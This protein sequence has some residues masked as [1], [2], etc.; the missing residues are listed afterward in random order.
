MYAASGTPLTLVKCDFAVVADAMLKVFGSHPVHL[1]SVDAS[2]MPNPYGPAAGEPI[3]G[4]YI[5]T[6]ATGKYGN[7]VAALTARQAANSSTHLDQS[8]MSQP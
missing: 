7:D 4:R 3:P 2:E 6:F 1:A 5:V 8:S